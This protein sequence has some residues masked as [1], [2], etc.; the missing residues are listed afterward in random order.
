M[1]QIITAVSIRFAVLLAVFAAASLFLDTLLVNVML[2]GGAL[3]G[4]FTY[5][6]SAGTFRTGALRLLSNGAPLYR[7]REEAMNVSPTFIAAC[8]HVL[9]SLPLAFFL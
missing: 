8:I 5:T 6:S 4:F 7:E 1:K 3:A 9:L 2:V